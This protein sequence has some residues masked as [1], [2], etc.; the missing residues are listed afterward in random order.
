[1]LRHVSRA[2]SRVKCLYTAGMLML[3]ASHGNNVWKGWSREPSQMPSGITEWLRGLFLL[4]FPR[5]E[6]CY[7]EL[8]L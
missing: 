3:E 2:F 7:T 1:M 6:L 8:E 5:Q 4:R